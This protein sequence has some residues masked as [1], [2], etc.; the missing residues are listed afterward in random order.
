VLIVRCANGYVAWHVA[1][2]LTAAGRTLLCINDLTKVSIPT[3]PPAAT[4]AGLK[5]FAAHNV[6]LQGAIQEIQ[7]LPFD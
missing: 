5:A 7:N 4:L 3:G 1:P 2:V 6:Q